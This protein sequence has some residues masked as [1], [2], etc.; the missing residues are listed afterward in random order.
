MKSFEKVTT[1]LLLRRSEFETAQVYLANR[2]GKIS[3][4][5][6]NKKIA[7]VLCLVEQT[8]QPHQIIQSSVFQYNM[9]II[10]SFQIIRIGFFRSTI[11]DLILIIIHIQMIFWASSLLNILLF[12][13][14][15]TIQ[16][17]FLC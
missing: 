1:Y 11:H 5:F 13:P 9:N 7:T 4:P 15:K 10:H 6:G 17:I 8:H 16:I 3:F 14:Y 12:F 2:K